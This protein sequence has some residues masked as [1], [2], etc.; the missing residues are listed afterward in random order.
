MK[1]GATI[2]KSK[3]LCTGRTIGNI[4]YIWEVAVIVHVVGLQVQE[5]IEQ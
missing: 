4:M 5:F 2:L 1:C 3:I